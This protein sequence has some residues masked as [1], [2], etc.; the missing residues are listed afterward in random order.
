MCRQYVTAA[1]ACAVLHFWTARIRNW[2]GRSELLESIHSLAEQ[3]LKA[4]TMADEKVLARVHDKRQ[5]TLKA[6]ANLWCLVLDIFLAALFV[7]QLWSTSVSSIKTLPLFVGVAGGNVILHRLCRPDLKLTPERLTRDTTIMTLLVFVSSVG[8]PREFLPSL[9]MARVMVSSFATDARLSNKVNLALTPLYILSHWC[10]NWTAT[11]GD[12]LI[13]TVCSEGIILSFLSLAVTNLDV[14]EYQLAAATIELEKVQQVREAERTGGA[15]QRLLSVTCDAFVRLAPDLSIFEP[16]RSL[17]DLLMCGFGSSIAASPLDGVPIIRYINEADHQRFTDFIKESS[18][19]TNPARS[20]HV[21]MKDSGGVVFN[22]E[23]FHVAV[24]G[25]RTE[26]HEHLIGIT[27]ESCTD[28]LERCEASEFDRGLERLDT[29]SILLQ[30]GLDDMQHILGYKLQNGC[31]SVPSR[32]SRSSGSHS[33][34]RTDNL[35]RLRN[36]EKVSIVVDVQTLTEDFLIRSMKMTFAKPHPQATG[37]PNLLEWIKPSYRSNIF[38]YIQDHANAVYGGRECAERPLRGIK[39]YSPMASAKTLL[40]G[41]VRMESFLESSDQLRSPKE[42]MDDA[43]SSS[44]AM[45][46]ELELTNLFAH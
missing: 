44:S 5:R 38:N 14:K 32:Q 39:M 26:E 13:F 42:D 2:R 7:S 18:N 37:V 22:V 25:L 11:S 41:E 46:M 6:I 27:Q 24:P 34:G 28:R 43:S 23:L 29:T 15:A 4:E 45:Y 3:P 16:S 36:L 21:G 31:G 20:L 1:Y 8:L 40:V 35:T 17:S 12:Q 10:Q 19:E 33:T 30:A 9:T